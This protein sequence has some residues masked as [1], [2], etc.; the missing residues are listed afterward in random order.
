MG[1]VAQLKRSSTEASKALPHPVDESRRIRKKLI[2]RMRRDRSQLLR[3]S[4]SLLYSPELSDSPK[5][6]AIG[7]ATFPIPSIV[8]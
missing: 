4:F 5:P 6:Q 2:R 3:R 7:R 1:T 8:N